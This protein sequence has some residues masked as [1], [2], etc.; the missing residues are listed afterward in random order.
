[1]G[2]WYYCDKRCEV[3]QSI[4]QSVVKADCSSEDG[5]GVRQDETRKNKKESEG[6][7]GNQG[8]G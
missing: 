5:S 7:G 6:G 8:R 1:M 4:S 3:S 2:T